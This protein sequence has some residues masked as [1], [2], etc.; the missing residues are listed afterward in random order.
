MHLRAMLAKKTNSNFII[1]LKLRYAV[2][3]FDKVC[4][5]AK[6]EFK[7]IVDELWN[8]EI[9]SHLNEVLSRG[10]VIGFVGNLRTE[11]VQTEPLAIVLADSDNEEH[12]KSKK[13]VEFNRKLRKRWR[14]R[15][16]LSFPLI[17]TAF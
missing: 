8:N 2:E 11:V 17:T 16:F 3:N 13:T 4:V 14:S 5:E 10:K 12:V 9:Q 15:R 6:E 1:N 7:L